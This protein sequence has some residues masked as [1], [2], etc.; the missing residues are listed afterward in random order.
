VND[1]VLFDWA[2][3]K[4]RFG[5]A[6]VRA[7][8]ALPLELARRKRAWRYHLFAALPLFFLA[9][10]GDKNG[11]DIFVENDDALK[12]LG[13]L[14]LRN[15]GHPDDFK[16]LTGEEQDTDRAGTSSDLGWVEI[17]DWHYPGNP[18]AAAALEKFRP[19]K[20]SRMGGDITSLYAPPS[21]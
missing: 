1:R 12:R 14:C 21:P 16:T 11:L 20:Q 9:E 4:T 2:M 7:D 17:Y 10:A 13:D 5:M 18:L 15:L 3:E 19:V 6:Q 8:G